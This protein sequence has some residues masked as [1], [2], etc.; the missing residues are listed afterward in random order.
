MVASSSCLRATAAAPLGMR[1]LPSW[2]HLALAHAPL[3]APRGGDAEICGRGS[4][5]LGSSKYA[6]Y[7]V[8]H[9][10]AKCSRAAL[11]RPEPSVAVLFVVFLFSY[12]PGLPVA[13]AASRSACRSG[14]P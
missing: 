4:G 5:A 2:A 3:T 14:L 7:L 6:H 12:V 10:T 1:H 11:L 9:S 8:T 13:L